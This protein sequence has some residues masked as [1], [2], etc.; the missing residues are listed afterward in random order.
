MLFHLLTETIFILVL[1]FSLFCFQKYELTS[2]YRYLA[3]G[4]GVLILGVLIKPSIKI[5]LLFT[6]LFFIKTLVKQIFNKWTLALFAP[7]FLLLFHVFQVNQ[8]F[9]DYTITYTDSKTYY[10][11]L[12][13]RAYC[14]RNQVLFEEYKNSRASYFDG[15]TLSEQKKIAFL[16]VKEQLKNNKWNLFKAYCIN[17]FGNA[18]KGNP[19]LINYKNESSTSYFES[20]K[21]I[22]RALSKL[23]NCIFSALGVVLSFYV[24]VKRNRSRFLWI[25]SVF[26][27]YF[28]GIS[29]ISSGQGDRF[30]LVIYPL[31]LLLI[32]GII[33][34]KQGT[35]RE[36]SE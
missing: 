8:Q 24:I 21:L 14:F 28:I 25:T 32:S 1:V 2:A 19:S 31:V 15:Q 6:T 11:Y 30:H 10:N 29:G 18:T 27:L 12:G 17:V 23:Q 9:G 20:F 4:I 26:I 33:C 5:L 16:D 35:I 36:P 34:A 22:F 13:T 3:I 7:L